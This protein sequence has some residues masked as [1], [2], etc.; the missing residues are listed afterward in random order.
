MRQRS[1]GCT[2]WMTVDPYATFPPAALK[3]LASRPGVPG[4]VT[5]ADQGERTG[6]AFSAEP[7]LKSPQRS[8]RILG[9][10][11]TRATALPGL[12]G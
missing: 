6:G 2:E 9:L 8:K 1:N 7:H 10:A 3:P 5:I 4:E 11:T 12:A